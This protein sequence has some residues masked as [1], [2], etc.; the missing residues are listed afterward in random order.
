VR[1]SAEN[2]WQGQDPALRPEYYDAYAL[3]LSKYLRAYQQQGLGIWAITPQNEALGNGGQWETMRWEPEGMRRFIRDHLGPRLKADGL[4]PRIFIYDHNKGPLDVELLPW[5][6]TI[7]N[8]PQAAKYV[9][10]TA[11]HWY[12]STDKVFE[13]SL[14]AVHALDP[15]KGILATEHTIDGLTDQKGAPASA[16]YQ[17]SWLKDDYYWARDAYDWGY[18]WA[19][20]ADRALHPAY[21]PVYRYARDI[22]VGLNHWYVGWIDWNIALNKDG[23]PNHVGNMCAAPVLVDTAART[24]YYTPLFY[25]MSHFSK[26]IRP[27]ARVMASS[28]KLASGVARGD[29]DGL[30]SVAARNPDGSIAVVLFNEMPAPVDYTLVLGKQ[31]AAGRIPAQSLQTLVWTESGAGQR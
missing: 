5:V 1:P 8:D 11:T 9:A 20:A 10:G 15:T 16:A 19:P 24:V 17:Y 7:L 3:Y 25:T 31:S 18:F 21:E 27:G 4:K 23:G 13:E 6:T 28:V 22:I 26:F 30:L 2:N 14:D 12:G 29:T